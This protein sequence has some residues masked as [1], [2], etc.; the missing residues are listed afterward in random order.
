MTR[1]PVVALVAV[2]AAVTAVVVAAAAF[3]PSGSASGTHG[4]AND[5]V[6]AWE[7]TVQRPAPLPPLRSLTV[8]D[9][10]GTAVEM[11]NEPPASR[12]PMF[13]TWKRIG[14]RLYAAT[15]EHFLFDP[16]TGG[17]A[18]TRKINRTIELAPD[19]QS[20]RVVA[21]ATTFDPAGNVVATLTA[22]ASG[23]R[24]QLE[25]IPERP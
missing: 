10:G 24:I 3:T 4:S 11:S 13:S 20:Y 22:T 23:R 5:L 15:G 8:F 7:Q 9:R 12:S 25:Q 19:R 2:A 21:R 14:G 18:G 6:G 16:Q 17:F 1:K